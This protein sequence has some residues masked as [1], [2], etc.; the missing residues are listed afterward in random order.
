MDIKEIDEILQYGIESFLNNKFDKADMYFTIVLTRDVNNDIARFGVMCID[1]MRD[2]IMEAKDMFSIYIFSPKEQKEAI[3]AMLNNYQNSEFYSNTIADYIQ[4]ILSSYGSELGVSAHLEEKD[5][6][7]SLEGDND[8]YDADFILAKVYEKLGDY[9]K[10]I[11]HIARAF[12]SKPFNDRLKREL[13][14][15]VR[16]KNGK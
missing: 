14:E 10:A 9:D 4:D 12:K 2:G 15:I 6:F 7:S 13:I 1:A 16:K 5:K 11:D 3:E 8:V